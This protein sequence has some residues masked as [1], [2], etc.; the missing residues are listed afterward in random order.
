VN[1]T[2]RATADYRRSCCQR[3]ADR[4][5]QVVSVTDHYGRI[6]GFLDSRSYYLFQVA[7][8]LYS[9]GWTSFQTDYSENLVA[10]GI[11]LGLLDLWPRIRTTRPQK[12]SFLIKVVRIL[13]FNMC[14]LNAQKVIYKASKNK[15][16]KQ[17]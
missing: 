2:D 15:I 14:L 10:L 8:Q 4:G 1:C 13:L 11:E 16:K 6:L 3:F 17:S 5:S 9:R 7:P 12:R